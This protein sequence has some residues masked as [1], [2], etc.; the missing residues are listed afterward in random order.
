MGAQPVVVKLEHDPR[1]AAV[2]TAGVELA[3]V[4]A[5]AQQH[6]RAHVGLA[7]GPVHEGGQVPEG[8]VQLAGALE[9]GRDH[10]GQLLARADGHDQRLVHAAR[11]HLGVEP[12][13]LARPHGQHVVGAGAAGLPERL[14]AVALGCRDGLGQTGGPGARAPS[15]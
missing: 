12:A 8:E 7:V 5:G 1:P 2:L 3:Q 10:T 11:G 14:D 9:V 15:K 13:R 6:D 4:V